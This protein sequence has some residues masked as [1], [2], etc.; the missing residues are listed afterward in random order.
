MRA[1]RVMNL[2]GEDLSPRLNDETLL[3]GMAAGD[4]HAARAFVARFQSRVFGLALG[5]LRDVASADDVA[6][7]AFVRCWRH[8]EAYD[9]TRGSVS[10][11]LLRITRNLAIDTLR[12]RRADVVPDEAFESLRAGPAGASLEDTVATGD[13][14][15]RVLAALAD[16]PVEQARALYLAAFQGRTAREISE[17]ESIPLGTAKTR[18]RLSLR[19]LRT[20]LAPEGAARAPS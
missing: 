17:L 16:L 18:I 5:I 6:Q 7:E 8:A 13:S 3:A 9:P 4:E 11:W 19:K 10:A 2:V 14:A 20:A 15:A 12:T 1:R